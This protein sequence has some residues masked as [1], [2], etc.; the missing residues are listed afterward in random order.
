MKCPRCVGFFIGEAMSEPAIGAYAVAVT[1]AFPGMQYDL[2]LIGLFRSL[3]AL[4]FKRQV[5][6]LGMLVSIVTSALVA[7]DLPPGIS[8]KAKS[9]VLRN[10]RFGSC[11]FFK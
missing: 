5:S 11:H 3:V 7:G 10:D 9:L 2:L 1:G 6:V 8:E 4:S